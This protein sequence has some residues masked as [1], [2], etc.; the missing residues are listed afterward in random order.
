MPTA[1]RDGEFAFVIHTRE[2]SF[3]PPHVHVRFGGN[4]V[5]IELAGVTFMDQ[6]PPGKRRAILEAFARHAA[7]IRRSW[8]Q[9]HGPL[10]GDRQ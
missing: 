4:H 8:E 7:R 2:L 9:I 1:V 5:R 3:E 10:E 6:P